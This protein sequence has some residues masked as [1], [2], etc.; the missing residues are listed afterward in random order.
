MH[1][2][3]QTNYRR[4]P[5]GIEYMERSHYP[6]AVV[7]V[8]WVNVRFTFVV[9]TVITL[10]TFS[11]LILGY[12]TCRGIIATDVSSG[13]LVSCLRGDYISNDIV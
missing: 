11:L 1:W 3:N 4:R 5:F 10:T 13:V 8:H 6:V 12:C 2:H 7:V 9:P